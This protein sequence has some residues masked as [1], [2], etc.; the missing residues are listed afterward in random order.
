MEHRKRRFRENTCEQCVCSSQRSQIWGWG[1]LWSPER[2]VL[3]SPGVFYQLW[4]PESLLD[5]PLSFL[6]SNE[7]TTFSWKCLPPRCL[8]IGRE[9]IWIW[10]VLHSHTAKQD[11][12]TRESSRLAFGYMCQSQVILIHYTKTWRTKSM[13]DREAMS[14]F[15]SCQGEAQIL[16]VVKVN[17]VMPPWQPSL[18]L[19]QNLPL[20]AT[21]NLLHLW[22]TS[23]SLCRYPLLKRK[24]RTFV[25]PITR[26]I[27]SILWSMFNSDSVVSTDL[28]NTV[29]MEALVVN[30]LAF[31]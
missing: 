14:C 24:A 9:E 26:G 11:P 29:A 30:S 8:A 28:Q 15:F 19:D 1:S 6:A 22:P 18:D 5:K 4:Q 2:V 16:H 27:L 12:H 13:L 21:F 7:K 31:K 20:P 3:L 10:R 17:K 23:L 25:I